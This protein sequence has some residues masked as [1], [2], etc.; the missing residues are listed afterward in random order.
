MK[1]HK[2]NVNEIFYSIQGEGS[3][4]GK[5]CIFLRFQ[6]CLLRC[7]WCDTPY[8]LERKEIANLMTADEIF[9]NIAKYDCKFLMLTGGEPLE[10]EYISEFIS[11]ACDKGYE[12]VIETNGQQDIAKVDKRA[13]C[14]LDIKCPDSK[15][16][17]KNKYENLDLIEAKDEV[18]FVIS[19]KGDFDFA[20]DV[21]EKHNLFK[22]TENVLF[23]P[24]FG[25]VEPIELANW[26][27][28]K[29]LPA[30]MQLQLH[31]YIWEPSTRGV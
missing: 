22:K 21:I 30:R 16:A 24:V 3:R 27:L 8:A 10:Q 29:N 13:V 28:E 14:I 31:K 1:D 4:I 5:P 2:F 12:V 15:M 18:K 25:V 19:S 26:I 23:S 9:A 17:K 20:L 7:V 11:E 6:G